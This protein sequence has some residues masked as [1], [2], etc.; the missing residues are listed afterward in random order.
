MGSKVK[1]KKKKTDLVPK[2]TA[3]LSTDDWYILIH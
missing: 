1:K 3:L 2:V